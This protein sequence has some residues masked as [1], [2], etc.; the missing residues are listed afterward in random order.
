MVL[1]NYCASNA[2]NEQ[3]KVLIQIK[4][5]L[6]NLEISQDTSVILDEILNCFLRNFSTQTVGIRQLKINLCPN[7]KKLRQKMICV[8]FLE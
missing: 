7:Y 6:D 5:I 4:N 2:E 1:V 3:V 8:I